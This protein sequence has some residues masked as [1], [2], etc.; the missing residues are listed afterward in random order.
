MR[1]GL[2]APRH[3]AI[4]AVWVAGSALAL[5]LVPHWWRY[6]FLI[7]LVYFA[8]HLVLVVA[9]STNWYRDR[10][11]RRILEL[12]DAKPNHRVLDIGCGGGS[13]SM[14]MA[15]RIRQGEVCGI[16]IWNKAQLASNSPHRALENAAGKEMG[17]LVNIASADAR[18]LPFRDASFDAVTS[19]LTI[20]NIK[21]QREKA[22]SEIARVLKD[23]GV[24]VIA[25]V[26]SWRWM[27]FLPSHDLEVTR[28][29]KFTFLPRM[30]V[31]RRACRT[32][33]VSSVT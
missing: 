19:V 14:A 12:S 26:Y 18:H 5:A 22:I 20:H 31:A 13:L 30:I 16:D 15:E 10:L 7:P 21:A 11:N 3:M 4:L 23:S 17:H 1:Y 32:K 2:Q 24:V 6:L 29:V 27:K 33:A 8:Y 25:D 28:T 9:S